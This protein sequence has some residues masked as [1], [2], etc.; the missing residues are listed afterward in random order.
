[1]DR[2]IAR[3]PAPTPYGIPCDVIHVGLPK[4][5]SSF[6]QQSGF[7]WHPEIALI[8][9]PGPR[10]F[11]ELRDRAGSPGFDLAE[12]AGRLRPF[13][14][15]LRSRQAEAKRVV[16]SFEGFCGPQATNRND[17]ALAEVLRELLGP[18]RVVL[19]VREPYRL[20]FSLWGQYI[21]EGGR[22]G[23]RDYLNDP[24]SPAR[25]ADP[26][27]NIYGRVCYDRYLQVLWDRF[28]R[29]NTGLFFFE[30]FV[31]D[32]RSFMRQ[33][34]EFTGVDPS[35]M[36]ANTTLWRGPNHF[37]ATWFRMLNRFSTSSHHAG[38]LSQRVYR[39]YRGLADRFV[40]SSKRLNP[41]TRIQ[42]RTRVPPPMQAA[43]ARSNRRLAELSGRDLA[44]LGYSMER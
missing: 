37:H 29:E 5:G 32:Y 9:E 30:D 33:L 2:S 1:M 22:L 23:L 8:W 34:Y 26:A 42:T 7:A 18:V 19:I 40:F 20:L 3:P 43:I 36:P 31:G 44:G 12:Y 27:E 25:P 16:F 4:C 15:R 35:L 28:G 10:L 24:R 13:V 6:L 14:A 41:T 17:A 21:R 11:F 39:R 38:W